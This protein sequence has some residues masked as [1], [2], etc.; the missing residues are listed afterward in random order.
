[1]SAMQRLR[2]VAAPALTHSLGN[3]AVIRPVTIV[4]DGEPLSAIFPTLQLPFPVGCSPS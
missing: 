3:I 4:L 1:M 2:P